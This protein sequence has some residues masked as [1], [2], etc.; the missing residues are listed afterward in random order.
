MKKFT[1]TIL[2]LLM[3]LLSAGAE[4]W[5]P[6]G[7]ENLNEPQ[8]T[9][10]DVYFGGYFLT[11]TMARFDNNTLSFSQP[12]SLTKRITDL[13]EPESVVQ[14]LS[15]ELPLNQEQLCHSEFQL[16]CGTLRPDAVGIIFDRA[17]LRAWLFVNPELL[18]TRQAQDHRYLPESSASWSL[19]SDNSL[20]FS[21]TSAA[22]SSYNLANTTQFAVAENRLLIR[23]NLTDA[24]GFTVD[25]LSFSREYAG[26][27]FAA[28]LFRGDSNNLRFFD[29]EQFVGLAV[30]SSVETRADLE[31]FQGNSIELFLETRSRVEIYYD[32]RLYS[33]DYYDVG[34]QV[35]DTSSLPPGSYDIEIR[36]TDAAGNTRVEN[37]YF[38]KNS[39]LAPVDQDLFFLQAG[40]QVELQDSSSLEDDESDFIRLGYSKRLS[41]SVGGDLGVSV[42]PDSS[43]LE[44]GLFKQ[45]SNYQFHA[46]LA[47]ES[48]GA[49]GLT[50]DLRIR[51]ERFTMNFNARQ[52]LSQQYSSQLS[53]AISQ[54]SASLEMPTQFGPVSFFYRQNS[55]ADDFNGKNY[56]MRWRSSAFDL[57]SGNMSA[58]FE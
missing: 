6:P 24:D 9:A 47:Y 25:T 46:G 3:P 38:A 21:E 28:G 31:Q 27:E 48:T 1:L 17:N 56:G 12:R 29:S 32:S 40:R 7:F 43:M 52:I 37:R 2:L 8:T 5:V 34:N 20:F 45:G 30:Q 51:A 42:T 49:L 11:T 26:K 55:R 14:L 50:S 36:I 44:A 53:E 16:D 33:T 15:A 41:A 4:D 58:S 54:Y 23:S 19:F 39:Q 22:E 10:V 13:L 35:L 18:K 57:G